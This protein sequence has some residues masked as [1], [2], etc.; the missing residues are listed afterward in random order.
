MAPMKKSASKNNNGSEKVYSQQEMKRYLGSL[1][2]IHDENLKAVKEGFYVINR[3]L[4]EHTVMLSGHGKT[5]KSHTEMIGSLMEDIS[6]LKND[7][8]IIKGGLKKKVDYDEFLSLVQRV[9]K[10]EKA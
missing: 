8:Q 6:I 4:D 7:T 2:E 1:A 10:L 3:K 5:L 9:N